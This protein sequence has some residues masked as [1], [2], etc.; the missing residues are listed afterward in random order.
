LTLGVEDRVKSEPA[1]AVVTFSN[2]TRQSASANRLDVFHRRVDFAGLCFG[3]VDPI[4]TVRAQQ[5]E[6][7]QEREDAKEGVQRDQEPEWVHHRPYTVHFYAP[8]EARFVV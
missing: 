7:D 2:V 3:T 1:R 5:D 6:V 8:F 4:V